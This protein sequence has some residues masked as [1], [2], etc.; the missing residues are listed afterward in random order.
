ML[1]SICMVCMTVGGAYAQDDEPV[2]ATSVELSLDGEKVVIAKP[3]GWV[4]GKPPKGSV[5]LMRRA[6]DP[7]TQLDV[8]YTPGVDAKQ[9]DGHFSTFHTNLKSMGL[10][11]LSSTKVEVKGESLSGEFVQTVYE[12]TAKK[13]PYRL[14]VWHIHRKNAVW[15]FT[16]FEP[17][18][19]DESTESLEQLV[20]KLKI[21]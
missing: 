1:A 10:K 13:K 6:G 9:C 8:R 12:L 17:T 4:I 21:S 18:G 16:L 20:K 14:V 2:R 3:D 11:K 15:F 7:S 19:A 5:A